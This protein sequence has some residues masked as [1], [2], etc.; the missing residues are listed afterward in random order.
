[1]KGAY[2]GMVIV[3]YKGSTHQNKT[4]LSLSRQDKTYCIDISETVGLSHS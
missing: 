3:A 4:D 1:M 2:L